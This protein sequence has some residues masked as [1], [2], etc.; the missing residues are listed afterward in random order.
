MNLSIFLLEVYKEISIKRNLS[1]FNISYAILES[2]ELMDPKQSPD[3][4]VFIII[5]G[6]IDK[7]AFKYR[8]GSITQKNYYERAYGFDSIMTTPNLTKQDLF[9][10]KYLS[11]YSE[12]KY[13]PQSLEESGYILRCLRAMDYE[14]LNARKLLNNKFK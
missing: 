10:D 5:T 9:E 7:V 13:V 1:N 4:G 8:I 2:G 11:T 14:I 6:G 3:P 12:D